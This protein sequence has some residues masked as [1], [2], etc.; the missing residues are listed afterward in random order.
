MEILKDVQSRQSEDGTGYNHAAAG[1]NALD[2]HIFTQRVLTP[3][4]PGNADGNNRN[5]NSGFEHLSD[6]QAKIG[7][8]G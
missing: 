7:R 3:R 2:D 8:C 5:R 1:A 4:G 6:F